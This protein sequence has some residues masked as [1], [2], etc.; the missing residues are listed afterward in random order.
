VTRTVAP[1]HPRSEASSWRAFAELAEPFRTSVVSHNQPSAVAL[2]LLCLWF[3]LQLFFNEKT[4]FLTFSWLAAIR[5]DRLFIVYLVS[6]VLLLGRHRH[7]RRLKMVREEVLMMCFFG[8]ILVSCLLSGARPLNYHLSTVFSLIGFPMFTFW[9]CRRIPFRRSNVARLAV[10][11][12][13]I[14]GYLGLCGVCEHYDWRLFIFP[15]YIFNPSVGIHFGRARGPFVQAAIFGGVLCLIALMTVWFINHVRATLIALIPLALMIAS[16]YLTDTRAVWVYFGLSVI[17]LAVT[18]N[19]AQRYAYATVLLAFA[20]A[21]SGALSKFS[22]YETTLFGR[23]DEAAQSRVV[24]ADA[25]IVM[26]KEHPLLGSGYGTFAAGVDFL[27][28]RDQRRLV[29]G[30]GNHNTFLGLAVEVGI[31]GTVPYVLIFAGFLVQGRRLWRLS[32][33][34]SPPA[35]DFAIS[36]LAALLGYLCL[37]QFGDVRFATLLNSLMF[38][39]YGFVFAWAEDLQNIS[40]DQRDTICEGRTAHALPASG[41][42]RSG[43]V[44]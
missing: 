29:V 32:K 22:M 39:V 38:A 23:R 44:R 2:N 20:V 3:A 11:M 27:R 19:G 1:S 31:V 6:Y 9:L 36:A 5:P 15:D 40:R 30:E 13:A 10:V 21:A 12:I 7:L 14:G 18:R 4:T 41:D 17:I 37:I 43:A 26:L 25:S 8:I 28:D 16:I 34:Y 24:L 33:T 42:R 35:R